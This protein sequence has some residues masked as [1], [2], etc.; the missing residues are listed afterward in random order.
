MV[1]ILGASFGGVRVDVCPRGLEQAAMC[2]RDLGTEGAW[3]EW[4]PRALPYPTACTV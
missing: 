3:D 1:G 2:A 4:G